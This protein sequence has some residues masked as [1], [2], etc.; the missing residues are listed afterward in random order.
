MTPSHTFS[1]YQ[2][3]ASFIV[4][5]GTFLLISFWPTQKGSQPSEQEGVPIV[6][7]T[8]SSEQN[9]TS[10]SSSVNSSE[11]IDMASSSSSVGVINPHLKQNYKNNE[12]GV[13]FWYGENMTVT[14]PTSFV[15]SKGAIGYQINDPLNY[16]E[17][18]LEFSPDITEKSEGVVHVEEIYSPSGGNL[19]KNYVLFTGKY[20]VSVYAHY[21]VFGL[22]EDEL[23]PGSQTSLTELVVRDLGG[24]AYVDVQNPIERLMA[25]HLKERTLMYFFNNADAIVASIGMKE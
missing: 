17:I 6:S 13:F 23:K 16:G 2:K 11:S 14:A 3:I 12:T 19:S 20:R 18:W 8:S 1:I 4:I 22:Y 24:D 15:L 10:T 5:F 7:P 21:D 25:V 9:I